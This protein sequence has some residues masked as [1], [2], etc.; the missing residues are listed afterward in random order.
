MSGRIPMILSHAS[1][2]AR[3]RGHLK[4]TSEGPQNCPVAHLQFQL[5]YSQLICPL[6][7]GQL[8][9]HLSDQTLWFRSYRTNYSPVPPEET[10]VEEER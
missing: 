8:L 5:D 4:V 7:Q 3:Q 6:E 10:N 1:V 9:N 2:V